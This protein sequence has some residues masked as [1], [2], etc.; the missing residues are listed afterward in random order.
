MPTVVSSIARVCLLVEIDCVKLASALALKLRHRG[1]MVVMMLMT[2]MII[3]GRWRFA[4]TS[5][6][7]NVTFNIVSVY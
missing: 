4:K 7:S 2:M 5:A 3:V 1:V 6:R